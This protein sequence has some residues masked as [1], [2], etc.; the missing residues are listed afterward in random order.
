[1]VRTSSN[2]P[3]HR[4]ATGE[5]RSA[6]FALE[7]GRRTFNALMKAVGPPSFAVDLRMAGSHPIFK[8]VFR[9][10]EGYGIV[11][12]RGSDPLVTIKRSLPATHD[13]LIFIE[14]TTPARPMRR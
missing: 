7:P 11:T 13:I 6:T 10:R 4:P 12:K 5:A 3:N 2:P 1:M 14:P 9:L 8:R